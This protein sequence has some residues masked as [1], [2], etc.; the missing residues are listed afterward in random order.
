MFGLNAWSASFVLYFCP[1]EPD[2]DRT[3]YNGNASKENPEPGEAFC[4]G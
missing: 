4:V 2:T 3:K 1:H